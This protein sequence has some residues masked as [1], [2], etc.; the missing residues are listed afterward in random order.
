MQNALLE[1]SA[2][3]LTGIKQ[4]AVLKNNFGLLYEWSLKTGFTVILSLLNLVAKIDKVVCHST[5]G[6]SS[7]IVNYH[8]FPI[9]SCGLYDTRLDR[10]SKESF[11]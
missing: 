10:L 11:Q 3:H 8:Q 7:I 1:H 9:H 6:I 4:L 2:I 5:D